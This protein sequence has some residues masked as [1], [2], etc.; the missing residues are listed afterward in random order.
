LFGGSV[1]LGVVAVTKILIALSRGRTNIFFLIAAAFVFGYL[2]Y[3]VANPSRTLAGDAMLAD[4]RQL[5]SAL[6]HRAASIRSPSGT[7]ELALLA[8]VFGTASLPAGSGIVPGKLFR[9]PVSESSSSSCGSSTSSCG[10]SGGSS[11]GGG[12][13]GGCGGCGS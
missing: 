3:L 11:C 1:L 7:N 6:K 10:S 13:G 4:L 5:F 9:K 2:L 8:A 12:C